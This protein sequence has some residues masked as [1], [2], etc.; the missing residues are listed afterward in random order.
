MCGKWDT[1][2]RIIA[3]II[4]NVLDSCACKHRNVVAPEAKASGKFLLTPSAICSPKTN[5]S[6]TV[7][8]MNHVNNEGCKWA[9]KAELGEITAIEIPLLDGILSYDAHMID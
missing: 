9:L 3:S 2:A 1:K 6:H 5:I 7:V 4:V 8:K